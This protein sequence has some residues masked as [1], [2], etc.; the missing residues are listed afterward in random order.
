M[1][2][3]LVSSHWGTVAKNRGKN[4]R[5]IQRVNTAYRKYQNKRK[6]I[7]V[8]FIQFDIQT[9]CKQFVPNGQ[10]IGKFRNL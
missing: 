5:V 10:N 6:L 1:W 2:Y 7:K 8:N 3:T 9:S 4:I